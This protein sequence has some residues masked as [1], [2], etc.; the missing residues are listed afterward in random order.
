MSL[1]RRFYEEYGRI[2]GA[3]R[4]PQLRRGRARASRQGLPRPRAEGAWPRGRAGPPRPPAA[5]LARRARGGRR[6]DPRRAASRSAAPAPRRRLVGR[7]RRRCSTRRARCSTAPPRALRPRDRRRGAGPDADAAADDRAAARVT[8]R[9]RSSA[10]S[11]RR[12]AR[13]PTRR[14]EE[15]LPHLPHGDE[16]VVEELRHAYR[17]PR[18]IM[19]LALPL[20]DRIAPDVAPPIAFRPGG[21]PPRFRPVAAEHAARRGVAG[22]G[23]L[24][25][26]D[27]L[28]AVIAPAGLLEQAE[29]LGGPRSSS[30]P[31]LTPGARRGS[32][33]TTSSSSSRR[34]PA[35]RALR[36]ADAA[37]EDARRRARARLPPRCA[38]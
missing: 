2:H 23:A 8:A 15:L 33:S 10:T 1:L 7:R 9:S 30:I 6:G 32:S 17:V 26:E 21:E 28:L 20:L 29:G 31:L 34:D 11:P 24:A 35:P 18:E 16:A 19:E 5:H 14:W 36:G 22:G 38:S 4:G 37:D 3:A 25:Q 13:S 12:P 27:G